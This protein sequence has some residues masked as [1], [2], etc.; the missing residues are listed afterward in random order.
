MPSQNDRG[1]ARGWLGAALVTL[2]SA[3]CSDDSASDRVVGAG[4]AGDGG[5]AASGGAAPGAGAGGPGSSTQTGSSSSVTVGQG[6]G[7]GGGV[8][9]C[10]D[11][12]AAPALGL[13]R[14]QESPGEDLY[15][16]ELAWDAPGSDPT[17]EVSAE[18]ASAPSGAAWAAAM[19]PVAAGDGEGTA[20]ADKLLPD[21]FLRL[22]IA[23]GGDPACAATSPAVRL[24]RP[25]DADPAR[26][27]DGWIRVVSH[28]HSIA[29]LKED[30]GGP[31]HANRINW[32]NGCF[33][34][35][36]DDDACHELLLRSFAES[37]LT[38][39]MDAARD[40]GI[41]AVIVTDHD[42]V[43]LWFTDTFRQYNRADASGPS[44]VHGLEWTSALGHLTVV[45]NFLPDVP[46]DADVYD[47]ATARAVHQATPLP[48]DAC[49]DTDENHDVNSPAFDGPDAP[50]ARADHR[51]HGDDPPTVEQ[52]RASIEALRAAGAMVFINH[53]TN[54]AFV[55]PPMKWQLDNLDIVDGVEVN[56]PDPTLTNQDAP[57]YW[58]I[59]GLEAGRRWVGIAGTDCHVNGPPYDGDTGCN[60]F[61]G[62]TDLT[63]MDAPYMWV[64]PATSTSHAASNAPDLVVAALRAGRVTVVQD[65]DP[66]VVVDLAIDANDDGL[67]DYVS[68]STIPACE[69][70]ERDAFEVQVRV[71]PVQSHDYNV[72]IWRLGVEEKILQDTAITAGTVWL[73]TTTLSRSEH[74]P[75]GAPRGHVMVQV[76]ENVSF[77]TDDDAGFANPIWFEAADPDAAPC[78]TRDVDGR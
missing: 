39:L 13:A 8:P 40:K 64:K 54:D 51:G 65:L 60:S 52:A 78:D 6:G 5:A 18:I 16:V 35:L 58:R 44:V 10:A 55:E 56:T 25:D 24:A 48:P 14:I 42:N 71:R 43:G 30:V 9:T 36:G 53:P 69:Q 1:T 47:L 72:S 28:T 4:G 7:A 77:N 70:P 59:Q 67:I 50:C 74:L 45:G 12:P 49:D 3:G 29:D 41:G 38:W 32:F 31:V 57:E 75:A 62:I 33:D 63:H 34:E 27:G 23:R 76:R 22:R 20:R 66:A 17:D 15:V 37:G 26:W 19:A 68:G 21:L 61:H 46:A 2:A 73:G 11:P